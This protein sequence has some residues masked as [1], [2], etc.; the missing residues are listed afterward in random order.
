[1][2]N[3]QYATVAGWTW[4]RLAQENPKPRTP[5][6]VPSAPGVEPVVKAERIVSDGQESAGRRAAPAWP[7]RRPVLPTAAVDPLKVYE[8]IAIG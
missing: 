2:G 4:E 1:M 6:L 8:L 7:R 5:T 3:H